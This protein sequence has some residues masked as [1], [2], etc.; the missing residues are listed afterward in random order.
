MKGHTYRGTYTE[1]NIHTERNTHE[2]TLH[3]EGLTHGGTCTRKNIHAEQY[4]HEGATVYLLD[5]PGPFAR[6]KIEHM[7]KALLGM[8]SRKREWGPLVDVLKSSHC[9]DRY[10]YY[11]A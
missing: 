8:K 1:M 2:G 9:R 10:Y 11:V 3:M 4:T 7:S 6:P 5:R